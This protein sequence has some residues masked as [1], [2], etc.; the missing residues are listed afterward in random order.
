MT[1][2]DS[3]FACSANDVTIDRIRE[4]MSQDLSESLTLEYKERHTP[5]LVTTVAAMANSY[6]GIILVGICDEN[7]PDRLIG[8]PGS[9]L[10]QIVNSCYDTLE[11]PWV[12]EIIEVPLLDASDSYILVVRIDPSQVSRPTLI[13]GAAPIRLQAR[14]AVADRSRLAE[15]FVENPQFHRRMGYLIPAPYLPQDPY[16]NPAAD[17]VLRTGLVLPIGEKARWRPLAEGN[18]ESLTDK[19]NK[20]PIDTTLK[21]F[22]LELGISNSQLFHRRGHNRARQANLA[23]QA[24][25]PTTD[26]HFPIECQVRVQLM[27]MYGE[28][29]TS[30]QLILDVVI[31]A[32]EWMKTRIPT[33]EEPYWEMDVPV[34]Y[35]LVEGMVGA[36]IDPLVVQTLSVIAE[37][38]L[39]LVPQPANLHFVT[40]PSVEDLLNPYGLTPVQD[41]TSSHGASIVADPSLDLLDSG[42]REAQIDDWVVQ[43][44]LDAGLMGMEQLLSNFHAK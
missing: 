40:G 14:N 1:S 32:R 20:S 36:L 43:I 23:W 27:G 35:E 25:N 8:V 3:L 41:G 4:L 42:D 18:V 9:T 37:V 5:E 22:M 12:P 17:L 7:R 16:G 31:R 13:K 30:L 2:I 28:P 11:P 26:G 6:G 39:D 21:K 24:G 15:L 38:D 44:G 10:V 19:L 29:S 33:L 34:L